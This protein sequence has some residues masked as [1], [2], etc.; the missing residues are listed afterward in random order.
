MQ[1][2]IP[3]KTETSAVIRLLRLFRFYCENSD[4]VRLR[5]FSNGKSTRF[6]IQNHR[7]LV[8]ITVKN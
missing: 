5:A 2:H 4:K 7:F 1:L 6:S 8:L 3:E